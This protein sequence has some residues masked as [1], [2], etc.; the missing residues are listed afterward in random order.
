M[1]GTIP[2]VSRAAG[3]GRWISSALAYMLGST[4]SAVAVGAVLGAIGS[5][6]TRS[7]GRRLVMTFAAGVAL[8]YGPAE[9]WRIP[10]PRPELRRQVPAV[11]RFMFP[12]EITYALYGTILGAGFFTP[13]TSTSL[14]VLGVWTGLSGDI[15]VAAVTFGIFGLCRSA[16]ATVLSC[17]LTTQGAATRVAKPCRVS[18]YGSTLPAAPYCW[19]W[20]RSRF[21]KPLGKEPIEPRNCL[22]DRG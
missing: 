15:T 21:P 6:A 2:T 12:P 1:V 14:Y 10:V 16:P 13:S 3:R 5:L 22:K 8:A 4:A 18:N 20:L 7:M 9:L 11:W 17:F 19:E